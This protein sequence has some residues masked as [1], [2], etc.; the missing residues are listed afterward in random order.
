MMPLGCW[1]RFRPQPFS[2]AFHHRSV[3]SNDGDGDEGLRYCASEGYARSKREKL[4]VPEGFVHNAEPPHKPPRRRYCEPSNVKRPA[5][6]L[7]PSVGPD[8][9]RPSM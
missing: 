6:L 7:P 1:T 4:S 9:T 3:E 5:P 2:F 8:F